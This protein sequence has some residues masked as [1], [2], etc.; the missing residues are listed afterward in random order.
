M[1]IQAAITAQLTNEI[2]AFCK[3]D[4]ARAARELAAAKKVSKTMGLTL[5][6][7]LQ[8]LGLVG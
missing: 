7:T 3:I 2:A 1:T 5:A 6:E 8:H 4:V